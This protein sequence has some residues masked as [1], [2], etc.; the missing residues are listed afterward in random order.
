MSTTKF[1]PALIAPCGMNCA[2][3][4]AYLANKHE[5][6]R[7]RGKVTWCIGCRPRGKNCFIKRKC[8]T[9]TNNPTQFC[10]ECNAVPCENVDR[11][12]RRYRA[13]YDMSMVENLKTIK[14][15]GMIEFLKSQAEKYSCP[16]CGDVICVHDGKCYSCGYSKKTN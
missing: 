6:P 4:K 11:V 12:D 15:K 16:N 1:A 8:K 5:V 2:I 7:Q 13:R 14:A 9:L 10:Y 3:C